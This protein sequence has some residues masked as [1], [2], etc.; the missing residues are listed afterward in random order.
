MPSAS[1]P[2]FVG[3]VANPIALLPIPSYRFRAILTLL[4]LSDADFNFL[5][6]GRK[7]LLSRPHRP[8]RYPATYSLCALVGPIATCRWSAM[9]GAAIHPYYTYSPPSVAL[10]C[11]FTCTHHRHL[12][13]RPRWLT[14]EFSM[15]VSPAP[16]RSN[17][18][19]HSRLPHLIGTCPYLTYPLV[20][21]PGLRKGSPA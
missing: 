2:V 10:L 6:T 14:H 19:D 7:Q 21:R 9:L 1:D 8:R 17:S 3:R 15:L 18:I 16:I 12:L 5:L 4:L 11:L 20:T 13:T